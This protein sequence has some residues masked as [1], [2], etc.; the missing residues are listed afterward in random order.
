MSNTS[1]TNPAELPTVSM[2]SAAVQIY[3]PG[4]WGIHA[5]KRVTNVEE[6]QKQEKE[7]QVQEQSVKEDDNNGNAE[8]L[9]K[10]EWQL[11]ILQH[12]S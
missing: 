7:E 12:Q 5:V 1:S 3:A 6:A 8:E 10:S 9:Q 2:S 11:F 4:G